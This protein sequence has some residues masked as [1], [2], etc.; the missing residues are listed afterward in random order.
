M[1]TR[2]KLLTGAGISLLAAPAL[3]LPRKS[4]AGGILQG[5]L[6]QQ[7]NNSSA[8]VDPSL[9]VLDMQF[10][11]NADDDGYHSLSPSWT[12]TAA[13]VDSGGGDYAA[14]FAGA[15]AEYI[16]VDDTASN[17]LQGM[18]KFTLMIDVKT[19]TT[20]TMVPV[21]IYNIYQIT[22]KA[23][24]FRV[25][26]ATT[27][28]TIA[29]YDAATSV[30]ENGSYH[31]LVINYDASTG[32]LDTF[33]DSTEYNFTGLSGNVETTDTNELLIGKGGFG[34]PLDGQVRELVIIKDV[35]RP[36]DLPATLAA[37]R[38]AQ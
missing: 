6:Q 27:G 12:G 30:P 9:L 25:R 36:A 21:E 33:V 7:A 31:K 11:N 23:T 22:L 8:A 26:F 35:V 19:D 32:N 16:T 29:N 34:D 10:E 3:W 2:R 37:L 24:L 28:T 1:L 17:L 14:D 4:R 15:G 18:S 13:Y 5:V 20:G 38:A